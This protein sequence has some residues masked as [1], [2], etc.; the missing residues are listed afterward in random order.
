MAL[1]HDEEETLVGRGGKVL[2][3]VDRDVAL[4]TVQRLAQ[5]LRK[6]THTDALDG[7]HVDV[8]MGGDDVQL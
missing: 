6:H 2:E 7:R 8:T 3:G 4:A 5:G 1:R